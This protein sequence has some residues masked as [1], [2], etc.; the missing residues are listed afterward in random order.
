[1]QY[2]AA[3]TRADVYEDVAER[4]GGCGDLT[5]VDV[6][7]ALTAQSSHDG[8]VN[9]GT[10]N[11]HGG[12]AVGGAKGLGPG[13]SGGVAMRRK[14]L[15][16][17]LLLLL[18]LGALATTAHAECPSCITGV[19]W[20]RTSYGTNVALNFTAH[21]EEGLPLPDTITGVVMQVDGQRTKCAAITFGK[22]SQLDGTAI[23]RGSFQAYG[24]Y[25][26]SGR[27]DFGGQIYEFTVPLDGKPGTVTL[28]ADQTPLTRG[29][30]PVRV[31]AQSTFPPRDTAAPAPATQ[32]SG[33][34]LPS[35]EPAFVIGAGVVLLTIVG[36]YVDRRRALAR[37]LAA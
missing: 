1:M 16:A 7:E 15:L 4:G 23:Y 11:Q 32:T 19:F 24:S 17:S 12:A 25:T 26:H 33:I 29:A 13:P 27:I 37:S 6:D 20:E 14:I 35:I 10:G 3:V 21:A 36:A 2:V 8:M 22:T 30:I 18:A 5:D 31:T 9:A 34:Q 28:A